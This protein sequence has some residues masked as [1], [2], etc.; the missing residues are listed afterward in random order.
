MGISNFWRW[1]KERHSES[2]TSRNIRGEKSKHIV[3]TDNLLIDMNGIIHVAAQSV[4]KYGDFKGLKSVMKRTDNTDRARI[5]AISNSIRYED[6]FKKVVDRIKRIAAI[7]EYRNRLV[8]CMDGVSPRCKVMQQRCRRTNNTVENFNPSNISPGTLFMYNLTRYIKKHIPY[9]LTN[10]KK[11]VFSDELVPGEGEH[12]CFQYIRKYGNEKESF[13]VYGGDADLIMLGLA[14]HDRDITVLRRDYWDREVYNMVHINRLRLR[15]SRTLANRSSPRTVSERTVSERTVRNSVNDF[16]FI[17]FLVGNDFVPGLPLTDI[18]YVDKILQWY[19]TSDQTL[20]I[21]ERERGKITFNLP[22]M[23]QLF[24]F[25][26]GSEQQ[27]LDRRVK[28]RHIYIASDLLSNENIFD[29]KRAYYNNN[30]VP[31]TQPMRKRGHFVASGDSTVSDT[32]VEHMCT[33]YLETLR[34]NLA[35]YL[36]DKSFWE[37]DWYFPFLYSPFS[38]DIHAYIDTWEYRTPKSNTKPA[39]PFQHLMYVLDQDDRDIVPFPMKELLA[40]KPRDIEY[41]YEQQVYETN[42]IARLPAIDFELFDKKYSENKARINERYRRRNVRHK[43]KIYK[44]H[45]KN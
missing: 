31:Y 40:P 39:E 38:S 10:G 15:I 25:L 24:C 18:S 12:L 27:R 1:L 23:K 17:F 2:I 33:L 3:K 44:N 45:N 8:L 13:C 14:S 29:Y 35:Y 22:Y 5:G 16:I 19:K 7:V 42:A 28:S 26:A 37:W 43:T 30:I 9:F 21:V 34:W 20:V 11:V 32:D 4:Y 6:V 36:L 41:D